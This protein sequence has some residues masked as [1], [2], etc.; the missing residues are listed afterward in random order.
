MADL[1]IQVWNSGTD[2]MMEILKRWWPVFALG[3]ICRYQ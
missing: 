2:F 1:A 3:C